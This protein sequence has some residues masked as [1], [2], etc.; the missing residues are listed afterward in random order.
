MHLAAAAGVPVTAVFGPTNEKATRPIGAD[1]AVV[2]HPVGCRPCMLRE[3]PIDHRCMRGLQPSR[4]FQ[5]VIDLIDTTGQ[6]SA[7]PQTMVSVSR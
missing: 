1:H 7:T 2:G 4:V 6:R 3:C 5:S